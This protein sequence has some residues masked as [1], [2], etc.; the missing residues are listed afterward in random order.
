M[1]SLAP[2]V[3]LALCK[4]AH[5]IHALQM[6]QS[7]YILTCRSP[8]HARSCERLGGFMLSTTHLSTAST[9]IMC[10]VV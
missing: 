9:A 10:Y 2:V 8:G 7:C 4:Y 1:R 3:Q 5:N 6:T